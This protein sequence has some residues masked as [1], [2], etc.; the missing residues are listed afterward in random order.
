MNAPPSS[1]TVPLAFRSC[2]VD[3][4]IDRTGAAATF[5]ASSE[6]LPVARFVAVALTISPGATDAASMVVN[7]AS[8]DAIVT[9]VAPR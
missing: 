5:S 2:S 3:P 9:V 8:P 4:E 6:V 7:A 1:A